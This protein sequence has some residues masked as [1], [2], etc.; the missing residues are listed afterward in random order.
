VQF[1][2]H[3]NFIQASRSLLL[4][5]DL[6]VAV[7][8]FGS[9]LL[10]VSLLFFSIKVRLYVVETR[11]ITNRQLHVAIVCRDD[12]GPATIVRPS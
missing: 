8:F 10:R 12:L 2:R 11:P 1:S 6:P 4:M 5:I 3:K 7:L 9:I